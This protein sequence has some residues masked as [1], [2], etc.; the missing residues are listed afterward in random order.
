MINAIANYTLREID[1]ASRDEFERE[2]FYKAYA[3][4]APPAQFLEFV[5]AAI[6]AWVLPGQ[7][8]MLSFLVIVPSVLG[9]TIGTTWLRKRVAAPLVGR[10]WSAMAIYFIPIIAMIAGTAFNAYAPADGHIPSAYLAGAAVGAITVLI[11]APFIRRYQHRRDQ[12][13]LDAELDD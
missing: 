12:A 4:S 8:S 1:R 6:L 7:M 3:I 13:R 5:V 9:N 2:T 10:N 11:L